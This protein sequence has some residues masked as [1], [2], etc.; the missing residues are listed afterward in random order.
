MTPRNVVARLTLLLIS[1]AVL[2]QVAL[3]QTPSFA[4]RYN[5]NW[6]EV[7]LSQTGD[8][9]TGSYSGKF[10]GTITRTVKADQLHFEWKQPNDQSG[11]GVFAL[12]PD[13]RTLAGTWGL[14]ESETNG[15]DWS[16]TRQ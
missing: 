14:N 10:T 12:S 7:I 4:G 13:G 9:V 1:L 11:H 2:S 6:G 3:G 16:G 15:G 8:H 5:T